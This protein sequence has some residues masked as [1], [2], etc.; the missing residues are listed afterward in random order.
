MV[1]VPDVPWEHPNFQPVTLMRG[2]HTCLFLGFIKKKRKQK[3]F[4][5]QNCVQIK[6]KGHSEPHLDNPYNSRCREMWLPNGL[7]EEA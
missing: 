6:E 3:I 2:T 7:E 4:S 1:S 5:S